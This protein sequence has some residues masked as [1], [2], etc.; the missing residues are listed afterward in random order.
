MDSDLDYCRKS[1]EKADYDHYLISLLMPKETRPALWTLG[2]F[3]NVIDTI[4]SSV[5]NPALGYMRLTWWRDQ[6]AAVEKGDVTRGQPILASVKAYL[7]Y[8]AALTGFI[9]DH[10]TLIET[11]D[12]EMSTAH[13]SQLLEEIL[14]ESDPRYK[15][16]E[17]RMTQ[18]MKKYHGTKWESRPPFL[19]LR[20]WLSR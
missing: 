5:T 14:G 13:Y 12:A 8:Y 19:A 2:A 18:I 6:I 20:L 4:P 16:L 11:P 9:N 10:E 1:F 17:E 7:P 3:R 15:K